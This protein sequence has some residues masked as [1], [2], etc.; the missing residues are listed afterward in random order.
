MNPLINLAEIASLLLFY[1]DGFGI[2]W[3]IKVDMQ[4]N[5]EIEGEL[6]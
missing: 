6:L 2:K 4:L 5:K 1:K 3:S